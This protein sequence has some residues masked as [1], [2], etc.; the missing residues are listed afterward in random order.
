MRQNWPSKKSKKSWNKMGNVRSLNRV[1]L[2]GRVGQDPEIS[3]I[4]SIGRDI[5]KFSL[6][7]NEGFMDKSNQW[8]EYT[9]WHNIVAWGPLSQKVER[10]VTKGSMVLIE[11]KIKTKKWKDKNDQERRNV[12]IEVN[13]LVVLER[14]N[15]K[16]TDTERDGAQPVDFSKGSNKDHVPD[17]SDPDSIPEKD[18]NE[19]P[20]DE[21]EPF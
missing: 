15:K 16:D 4:P 13:N 10:N 18:I 17:E 8:K 14:A 5:A 1:I 2:V 3:H 9:E 12:D 21:S 6:A 11:G 19:F 7:T 20:Y